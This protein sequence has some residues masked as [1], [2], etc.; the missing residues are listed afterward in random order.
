MVD[1]RGG[2][3]QPKIAAEVARGDDALKSA[4]LLLGAGLSADAVSRA[5]F[6]ALH[7]ARALVSLTAGEDPKT[8]ADLE[9]ILQRDF[10]RTGKLSPKAASLFP[11]LMALRQSA[12]YVVEYVFTEAMAREQVA[13]ARAFMGEARA[14]LAAR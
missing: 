8:F 14:L 3:P 11:E 1:E 2:S 13:A 4:D 5:Y 6:A 10:V 12:D 7:Y 9:R